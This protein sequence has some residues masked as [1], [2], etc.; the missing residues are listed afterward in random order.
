[1][2]S[3]IYESKGVQDRAFSAEIF[4][5]FPQFYREETASA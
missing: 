4:D 5:I 3:R 2:I 1:M